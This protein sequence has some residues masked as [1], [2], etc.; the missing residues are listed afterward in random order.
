MEQNEMRAAMR[1]REGGC[2]RDRTY[3]QKRQGMQRGKQGVFRLGKLCPSTYSCEEELLSQDSCAGVAEVGCESQQPAA[4]P[5]QELLRARG[6]L[7]EGAQPLELGTAER[8]GLLGTAAASMPAARI[9]LLTWLGEQLLRM[10]SSGGMLGSACCRETPSL[11]K[12][13]N[14]PSHRMLL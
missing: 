10:C 1:W 3:G 5:P 12:A 13:S 6:E 4:E 7:E 14:K 9:P 11:G 8:T 2:E